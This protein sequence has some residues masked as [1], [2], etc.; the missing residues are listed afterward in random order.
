[1]WITFLN[2]LKDYVLSH[3]FNQTQQN[4]IK[5][6]MYSY[7]TTDQKAGDSNSPGRATKTRGNV[8][9]RGFLFTRNSR[10]PDDW[11]QNFVAGRRES[12][13]ENENPRLSTGINPLSQCFCI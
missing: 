13:A 3:F 9:F 11:R 2:P 12:A 5:R 1:M 6:N 7:L 10:A 8:D 4:A